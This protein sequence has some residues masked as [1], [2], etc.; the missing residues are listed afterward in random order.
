MGFKQRQNVFFICISGLNFRIR[1]TKKNLSKE[2]IDP[3]SVLTRWSL[4]CVP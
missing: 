2:E 1:V 3:Q 4:V